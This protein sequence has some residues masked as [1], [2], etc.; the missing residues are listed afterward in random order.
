MITRPLCRYYN[1]HLVSDCN[2]CPIFKITNQEHC[3]FK[4][5]LMMEEAGEGDFIDF[6]YNL[7]EFFES[8]LINYNN[9]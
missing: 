7:I 8:I 3:N 6:K 9:E 5:F 1:R 2:K 4:E